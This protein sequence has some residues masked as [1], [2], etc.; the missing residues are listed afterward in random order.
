MS[1]ELFEN[2]IPL[3]DRFLR[4]GPTEVADLGAGL[5]CHTRY[6]VERGVRVV[7]VDMVLTDELRAIT[8]G[9]PDRCRFVP[10]DLSRLPFEDGEL[11]S[12]WASYCLEHVDDPLST[13]REWRRVLCPNGILAVS[14]PPF[15]TEVV[16][17]H[18]FTGW[19]VG[20]LMLTLFRTGFDVRDGAYATHH[21]NVFAVVRRA[22]NP[23][24]LRPNDEILCQYH[25]QFP[26]EIE[27]AILGNEFVNPFGETVRSF[28]GQIKRLGW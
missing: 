11:E 28:E 16:G 4:E 12:L 18:V 25:D 7:A 24:R 13:L 14:V 6:F 9:H 23:P 20:Q 8:A 26:P 1:D 2:Q 21:Y 17:R 27:E 3:M 22:E 10:S 15:K 19:S 5:G